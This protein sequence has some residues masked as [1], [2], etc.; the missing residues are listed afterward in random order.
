[1]GRLLVAALLGG[2]IGAERE[3]RQKSAGLRTNTLIALGSALFTMVSLTL[4]E[5]TAEAPSRVAAQ[6]VTGVGFLG[7]GAI[8]RTQRDITGLTTAATI[9]VNAA[10]GMAVGAGEYRLGVVATIVTLVVLS[11]MAPLDA[12][13]ERRWPKDP[14]GRDGPDA[15]N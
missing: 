1:V 2:L 5:G 15:G 10:I 3:Y 4:V 12:L 7:A 6:I 9:W 11:V 14:A 8:L 13:F